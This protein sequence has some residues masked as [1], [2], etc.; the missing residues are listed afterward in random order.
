MERVP[1]AVLQFGYKYSETISGKR[2]AREAIEEWLGDE[3]W[4]PR[5]ERLLGIPEDKNRDAI[6]MEVGRP[7]VIS[8]RTGKPR[9]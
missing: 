8:S 5:A 1:F 3:R 2:F 6:V 4:F 9:G 7:R